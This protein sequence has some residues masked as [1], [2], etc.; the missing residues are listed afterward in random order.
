MQF[1][2]KFEEIGVADVALVGGKNA[3]LGQMITNLSSAKEILIPTGFAITTDAYWYFLDKNGIRDR[4]TATLKT[5]KDYKDSKKLQAVG[6]KVREL[7]T[8]CPMPKD[9]SDEIKAAYKELSKHYKQSDCD[10]AVRSSASA[11]DLPTAS[12]AGQQETYLNISGDKAL[13]EAVKKCMASLFTD[14]AIAY[15]VE[16]NFE[17]MKVGLSVGVQKMVR[18]DL[19]CSG[20]AFSLDTESGFR[21]AIIIDSSYGLGETIVQ[22]IVTPDSFTVYK[23]TLKKGFDPIIKKSRGH[24]AVKLVYSGKKGKAVVQVRVPKEEQ[25]VF[26]LTDAEIVRLA[27]AVVVIEDYYESLYKRWSPMDIE[28]AKDGIDNKLYIV[29]ARPETVHASQKQSQIT[30]Y[31]LIDGDAESQK[32]NL[33]CTGQSIGQ[34]IVSGP[35]RVVANASKIGSIKKGEIIVTKMTDPDWVPAMKKAAGII[36]QQGG[37]TCHAA[38]VSR[39]LG[40]PAVVGATDVMK[41]IKDGEMIT[42]DCS[43]GNLAYVYRGEIPFEA[44]EVRLENIPTAPVPIMVNIGDPDSAFVTSMLP[45][46]GVGLARIEFIISG[47]IKVHPK[48]ITQI[49][50][51]TNKADREQIK[52]LAAAYPNPRAFFIDSLAQGIATIAAAFYPRPVIVRMSD[53]KTNEYRNLI[54]GKYFEPNEENPMIGWRGASRYCHPDY[55]DAFALE[56]AAFKKV[57]E[58]MGLDNIKIMIPFVRR[59]SEALCVIESLGKNG[60]K[61]GKDGLEIVMMVE[62]PSNVILIDEF[63]KIFD[64]FSIGSNDLTQL[65]LAVDRDSAVLNEMFDER[66]EAVKMMMCMA[67]E[68]AKRNKKPIG[69]CGQAPSDYPEIAEFLIEKGVS[70]LSLNSDSVIPFLMRYK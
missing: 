52:L 9:L 30:T 68:G 55:T 45:V 31:R 3:S 54:G 27:K 6:K 40:I 16:N 56:C 26:S 61:R 43:R 1:I 24:K 64:G 5:L 10:V 17:H 69:I 32:K 46:D 23:P 8:R 51:V 25:I 34:K 57:R 47:A 2:K 60:L 11:E 7:I 39:E 41:Q 44:H 35:A 49:G 38:I 29:Q 58:D 20:I 63:S 50:K 19:A 18:S 59:L 67:I 28:W 15:R 66:D 36:T 65:T 48:A 12:F 62:V 13:I 42:I 70:S 53:F 37:R 33:I 22:G 4:I 14:R 21:D